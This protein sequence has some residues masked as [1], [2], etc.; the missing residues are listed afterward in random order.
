MTADSQKD[1][2]S[3]KAVGRICAETLRVMQ[4]KVRAGMTARERAFLEA[5]GALRTKRSPR[6]SSIPS[7]LQRTSRSSL[8]Y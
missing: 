8:R 2:R 1:I 5:E 3:L 6:K 7:S 4:A